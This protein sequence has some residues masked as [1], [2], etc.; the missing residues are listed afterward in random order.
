VHFL[1]GTDA[2]MPTTVQETSLT[3]ERAFEAHQQWKARLKQSVI[4]GE[5]LDVPTIRR[6]DC[7]ALGQWLHGEG[8]TRYG[9][10]PEFSKLLYKHSGFHLVASVVAGIINAGQHEEAME[11]LQDFSHFS[12]ASAEVGIAIMALKKS[13]KS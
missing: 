11:M 8:Y 1:H 4:S 12:T 5:S 6:D 13:L 10:R 2:T 3:L 7:C 9:T